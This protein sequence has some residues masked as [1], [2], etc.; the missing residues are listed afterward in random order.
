[1][2]RLQAIDGR[3]DIQ[4]AVAIRLRDVVVAELLH[5]VVLGILL[6]EVA[7]QGSGQDR[8]VLR[9]SVVLWV[10]E[11]AGVSET[12]PLH[13][14]SLRLAIHHLCEVLLVTGNGFGQ[15]DTGVVA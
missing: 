8:Q 15:G 6:G 10:R 2:T 14:Q 9:R 11:T 12:R 3:V 4:Q 5:R 7:D 13:A 1:M